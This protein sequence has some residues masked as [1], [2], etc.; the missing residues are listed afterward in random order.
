MSDELKQVID[1]MNSLFSTLNEKID[2]SNQEL[3]NEI[4]DVKKLRAINP[5]QTASIRL[6]RTLILLSLT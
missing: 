4:K 5:L 2:T 3:M 6:K 1:M